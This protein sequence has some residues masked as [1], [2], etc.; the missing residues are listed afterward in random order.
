M[1]DLYGVSGM[2]SDDFMFYLADIIVESVQYGNRSNLC[3]TFADM[4]SD[5][6]A[7]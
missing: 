3:E 1:C 6:I 5:D 2:R 7:D 4:E